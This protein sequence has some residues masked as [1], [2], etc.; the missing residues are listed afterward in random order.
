M[1]DL[2]AELTPARGARAEQAILVTTVLDWCRRRMRAAVA[3][4]KVAADPEARERLRGAVRQ[5]ERAYATS[6]DLDRYANAH[7]SWDCLLLDLRRSGT[8]G[9]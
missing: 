3:E 2:A 4:S 6:R 9:N 7:L 1:L 5:L 8:T